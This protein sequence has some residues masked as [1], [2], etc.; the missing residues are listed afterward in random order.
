M[1]TSKWTNCLVGYPPLWVYALCVRT[2][3][4]IA[5]VLHLMNIIFP[6]KAFLW[7][8]AYPYM[9]IR[10]KEFPWGMFVIPLWRL[11]FNGHL[12]SYW[13]FNL[14]ILYFLVSFNI[15]S[16]HIC[17]AFQIV[18]FKFENNEVLFRF[19]SCVCIPAFYIK[20]GNIVGWLVFCS[21]DY[22]EYWYTMEGND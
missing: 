17:L 16:R 2:D 10:N 4:C 9:H 18:L 19:W 5:C 1:N 7:I 22:V 21:I 14:L 11:E 15:C 8:Q 3:V 6:Y 13:Y 12:I 20:T